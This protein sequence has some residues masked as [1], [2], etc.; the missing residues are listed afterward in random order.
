MAFAI[1]VA[2]TGVTL[3][4]RCALDRQADVQLTIVAAQI[5]GLGNRGTRSRSRALTVRRVIR[6]EGCRSGLGRRDAAHED[7]N[8]ECQAAATRKRRER[9]LH[10][11]ERAS[12][13]A[14]QAGGRTLCSVSIPQLRAGAARPLPVERSA[15]RRHQLPWLHQPIGTLGE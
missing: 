10:S 5:S 15:R 3:L 4:I 12:D 8:G 7:T 11:S 1:E 2:I 9:P 6:A 13:P 14:L